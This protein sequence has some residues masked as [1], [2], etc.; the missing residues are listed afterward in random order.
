MP[1]FRCRRWLRNAIESVLAQTWP[2]VDLYVVDD[3]SGD[4]DDAI[5][6]RFP[7]V[8]FLRMRK[9]VGP[10]VIDNV[11]LER[12]ESE[13]IAFHDADDQ[14][15]RERIEAQVRL[16]E[17][18]GLGG[19]GTWTILTD[20]H[21]D[22]IGYEA[23][24]TDAAAAIRSGWPIG[25]VHPST[26]YDRAVFRQLTGFD[27]TTFVSADTELQLRASLEFELG[28]VSRF[29]YR[30][31]IRPE[32]LTQHPDT[33]LGSPFRE[34]Y[35]RHVR[36]AFARIGASLAPLPPA[37]TALSGQQIAAARTSEIEWV[38]VGRGNA[39]YR[40]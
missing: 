33:G 7:H 36:E 13:F 12:T 24:P 23:S 22:P 34:A 17:R 2:A 37:G 38:R 9:R 5:V 11:L 4:V 29:L 35:H 18:R 30:R 14:S 27:D 3:A 8:T 39:T 19:C 40:A 1:T 25:M 15:H 21:G 10:Y 28:N 26:L 20:V 31:H 32:S 16:V 6:A